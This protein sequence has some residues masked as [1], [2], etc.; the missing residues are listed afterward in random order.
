MVKPRGGLRHP[1]EVV[2]VGRASPHINT[3]LAPR[4]PPSTRRNHK[5]F[6]IP[7]Q[8]RFFPIFS[9]LAPW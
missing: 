1:A 7:F 3:T 9:D 4:A 5:S 2:P 6:F 8:Q